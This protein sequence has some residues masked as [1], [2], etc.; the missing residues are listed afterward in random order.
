MFDTRT[1]LFI[2]AGLWIRI[3][4]MRIRQFF[5]NADPDPG[6]GLELEPE[7]EPEPE[8]ELE[9]EPEPPS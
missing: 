3:Y 6:P 7:P 4:F 2:F 1:R 8:L 9:P 5:L